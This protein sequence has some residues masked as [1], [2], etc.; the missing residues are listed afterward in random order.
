MAANGEIGTA[1]RGSQWRILGWG[2]AIGLI[3]LPLAAMQ[4]TS[5]VNWNLSDFIAAGLMLGVTGGALELAVRASGNPWSRAGAA[6]MILG[7]LMLVW[8]NGAVGFLG[9][10]GN[11]A[12]LVFLL[13]LG[14]A[15]GGSIASRFQSAQMVRTMIAT[16]VTQGGIGTI[17]LM[18]GWASPGWEGIYEVLLGTTLFGGLWLASAALFHR[19]TERGGATG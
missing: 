17:A 18:A 14:I 2:T 6:V 19:A 15:V 12:N 5:E 10:E 16:A 13:V 11:P 3:L 7:C 9:D 1:R 4:F 8:V